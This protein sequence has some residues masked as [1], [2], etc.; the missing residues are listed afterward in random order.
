MY[1]IQDLNGG[2]L[3]VDDEGNHHGM[4]GTR[5]EAE[6][7]IKTLPKEKPKAAVKK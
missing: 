7:A 2:Y 6:D 4:F 5:Q 1:R 3:I